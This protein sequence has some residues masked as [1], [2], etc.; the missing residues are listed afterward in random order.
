MTKPNKTKSKTAGRSAAAAQQQT[1]AERHAAVLRASVNFKR[2]KGGMS[3]AERVVFR[4]SIER[5]IM[6]AMCYP[7]RCGDTRC[8]RTLNCVGLTM[9]C[10]RDFPAPPSTPEQIAETMAIVKEALQRRLAELGMADRR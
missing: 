4:K 5:R 6:T 9:R 3:E 8:R 7:Q 1:E 2:P 10:D